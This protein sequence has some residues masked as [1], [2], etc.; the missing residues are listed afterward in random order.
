[1]NESET[2]RASSPTKIQII[3]VVAAAHEKKEEA[4]TQ[5]VQHDRNQT[6]NDNMHDLL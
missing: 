5:E 6:Y 3:G 4:E 2:A 1:M